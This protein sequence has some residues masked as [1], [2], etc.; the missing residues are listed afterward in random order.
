MSKENIE[1]PEIAEDTPK[2]GTPQVEQKIEQPETPQVE[3]SQVEIKIDTAKI[4]EEIAETVR[5]ILEA[6]ELEQSEGGKGEVAEADEVDEELEGIAERLREGKSLKEQWTVPL[7]VTTKEL[8]AHLR[9]FVFISPVIK[10]KQGDT[11]NIPYVTD[12]DFDILSTVGAAFSD[13]KAAP[14]GVT[15]ASL[16]EAGAWTRVPYKDIEKINS[17]LLSQINGVFAHAG[18]RSEDQI[19]LSKFPAVTTGAFG[20]YID[21]HSDTENFYSRYIP[22]ALGKLLEAG[23]EANPGDCVLYMSPAMYG[24]FLKELSASQPAAFATPEILRTGRIVSYMG[25]HIVVGPAS[26]YTEWGEG[27]TQKSTVACAL[28]GRFKR[29][30]V[31]APKREM[32][33]E[34]EKDT[35]TRSLKMTASHTLAAKILDPK[36]FVRIMTSESV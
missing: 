30:A 31:L 9:D 17:T 29:G 16:Q 7:P 6:K 35:V 3:T 32:L 14:Y 24:A 5:K 36:E 25:V 23:K 28:L 10:G 20:G 27:T 11:V 33:L 8:A 12:L 15:T 18:I 34:T 19:I 13:S 21:G 22:Q 26:W 2:E 1:Q 4:R